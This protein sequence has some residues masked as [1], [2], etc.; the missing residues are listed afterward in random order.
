M[1]HQSEI[2]R[3]YLN[4]GAWTEKSIINMA[5]SGHFSSDNTIHRYASDIWNVSPV[6]VGANR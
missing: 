1:W 3:A 4:T 6:M 5:H 2:D